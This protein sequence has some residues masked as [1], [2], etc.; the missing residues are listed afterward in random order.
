MTGLML[1]Y[2]LIIGIFIPEI[3]NSIFPEADTTV[4]FIVFYSGYI[5]LDVALRLVFK[6]YNFDYLQAYIA[7]PIK[8]STLVTFPLIKSLFS[9]FNVVPLLLLV[10]FFIKMFIPLYDV[11]INLL[12]MGIFL[13]T[14]FFNNYLSLTLTKLFSKSFYFTIGFILLSATL[15]TSGIF[16]G[17]ELQAIVGK[18]FLNKTL[19]GFI[20]ISIL[21]TSILL[22]FTAYKLI[23]K[24][25]Y[26]TPSKSKTY[27]TNND[28]FIAR[29]LEKHGVIGQLILLETKLIW[30]NNRSKGMIFFPFGMIV[31]LIY[32]LAIN[33]FSTNPL[34]VTFVGTLSTAVFVM[35]YGQLLFSWE[36]NYFDGI[37][38]Q[39]I[40]FSD[41]LYAKYILLSSTCALAF[42]MYIPFGIIGWEFIVYSLA[43][44]VFNI[45][46]SCF[47]VIFFG[48]YNTKRID[49]KKSVM[50]NWEGLGVFNSLS[51]FVYLSIPIIIQVIFSLFKLDL[52]GLAIISSL[53]IIGIIFRKSI[54]KLLTHQFVERKYKMANGFRK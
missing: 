37:L 18:F 1:F 51:T 41:Y 9:F 28:F 32:M 25:S 36:S 3:I 53:G 49:L 38:S 54:I 6:S 42:I 39:N 17:L 27:S 26:I 7:L 8:R 43:C 47:L 10:P 21:T 4:M 45:G 16:N 12:W 31:Y 13:S 40:D 29:L 11:G 34:V 46:V 44:A 30:R 33:D 24:D 5:A 22:F 20:L 14:I 23:R 48:T 50:M 15:I 19:L 35:N 52:V 2:L